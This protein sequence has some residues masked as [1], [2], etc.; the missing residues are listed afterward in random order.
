MRR[1]LPL[2]MVLATIGAVVPASAG[3]ARPGGLLQ[4]S[5]SSGPSVGRQVAIVPECS[6]KKD[7]DGDGLVDMA[8]PGCT[9]PLDND[10]YNS[11][12]PGGGGGFF[13]VSDPFQTSLPNAHDLGAM[14][15][16]HVRWVHTGLFW[17]QIEPRRGLFNW[18][19]SDKIIGDLASRGIHV[20]PYVYA[21]ARYVAKNPYKP[22]LRSKRAR[23][24][25]Q[26]FLWTL[27]NRYGPGGKYWSNPALYRLHHPGAAPV[28]ITYWQIWTEPN[29]TKYFLPRPSPRRYAKLVRISHEAI[30]AADPHAKVILAGLP[31]YAKSTAWGFLNRLYK[32]KGIKHSFEGVAVHPYAASVRLQARALKRTR[33]V[34]K[35]RHDAH[36]PIWITELGW[37]SGPP[38]HFH[39]NKGVQGQAQYLKKS[40]KMVLHH[41]R[42][43][44]I[45]RVF[46]FRW[47]D[48]IQPRCYGSI[49]CSAG[50]LSRNGDPKPAWQAFMRFSRR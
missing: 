37:G 21:T 35:Q 7:D 36:T 45:K 18:S 2:L 47:R 20:L 50:L 38:D 14:T 30:R 5:T 10:E 11:P 43:W 39:L 48:P 33:K 8:D 4:A 19:R 28:P 9:G 16:G 3:N 25:W 24:A 31:A 41:R 32:T 12:P 40:F 22:P 6:N 26:T 46:W 29:L 17:P 15:H 27:V 49:A 1:K 13:A 42:R 23:R 44:N 34:I